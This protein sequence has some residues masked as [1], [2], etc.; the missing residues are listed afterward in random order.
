MTNSPPTALTIIDAPAVTTQPTDQIVAAGVPAT[1]TAAAT[2]TGVKIQWQV[3][4]DGGQTFT[5]V[6]GATRATLTIRKTTSAMNGNLYRAVF[7][8][9]VGMTESATAILTVTA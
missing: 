9:A 4:T 3:S 6:R 8:N 5:V 1:F 7:T 2:G